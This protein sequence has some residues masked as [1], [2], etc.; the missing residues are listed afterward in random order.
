MHSLDLNTFVEKLHL[1]DL[2]CTIQ[3]C[4]TVCQIVVCDPKSSTSGIIS[5][6]IGRVVLW[7]EKLK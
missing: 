6:H 7:G 1:R 5:L 3:P 2:Y 4:F